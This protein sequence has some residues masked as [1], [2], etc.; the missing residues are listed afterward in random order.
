MLDGLM[1]GAI[2]SQSRLITCERKVM[3]K[4]ARLSPGVGNADIETLESPSTIETL[5]MLVAST[6]EANAARQLPIS[7]NRHLD[8]V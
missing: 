2:A 3:T 5:N 8:R 1:T 6:V 4:G 7:V